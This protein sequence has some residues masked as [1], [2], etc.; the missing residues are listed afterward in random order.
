MEREAVYVRL[1]ETDMAPGILQHLGYATAHESG[2]VKPPRNR[3][4]IGSGS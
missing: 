1:S 3:R 4:R 2:A